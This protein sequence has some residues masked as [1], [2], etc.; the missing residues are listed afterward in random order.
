MRITILG[1]SGNIGHRLTKA[2][3]DN[4]HE[5]TAFVHSNDLTGISSEKL[6]I[7]KGDVHNPSDVQEAVAGSEMVVSTLGSWGSKTKDIVGTAIEN[8][9]PAMQASGIKRIVSL[10]GSAARVPG[11]IE[12]FTEKTTRFLLS[13]IAKPILTDGEKS[14]R[15]LSE[16]KLDWTVIRSPAMSNKKSAE[17][18]L[19]DKS[20]APWAR[21]SRG[22]VVA[23]LVELI[24][25]GGF[26]EQAP[27]ISSK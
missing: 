5:V 7:V 20:S 6:H 4:G 24:E 16:S 2:L 27:F 15:I 18:K 19:S 3:L 21:I 11:Q 9:V 1:A 22:A 10:T 26:S 17:F 12:T 13:A 25:K 14:L 8:A 23:A